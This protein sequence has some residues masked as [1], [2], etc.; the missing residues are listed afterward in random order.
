MLDAS[1]NGVSLQ[2]LW[3]E[4]GEFIWG[5]CRRKEEGEEEVAAEV[6]GVVFTYQTALH[7]VCVFF[8]PLSSSR[9]T[10]RGR[11]Y[12]HSNHLHFRT[13]SNKSHFAEIGA[14]L[15]SK[16]SAAL[17]D[18][19]LR[20]RFCSNYRLLLGECVPLQV[21]WELLFFISHFRHPIFPSLQFW[22]RL[23]QP[24]SVNWSHWLEVL[25]WS[26]YAVFQ[27][28]YLSTVIVSIPRPHM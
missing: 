24:E 6:E 18:W 2:S 17:A 26:P 22:R 25:N 20:N 28:Y 12:F 16:P 5:S 13:F 7:T 15:R 14:P 23:T 1:L 11:F 21:I 4:W 27:L 8:F 10:R 3:V 9:V 19:I